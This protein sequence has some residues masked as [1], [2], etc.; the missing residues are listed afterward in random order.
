MAGRT[1]I[2]QPE[3]I[4]STEQYD[5]TLSPGI[6]LQTSSS[7][8]EFDLNALRSQVR[9]IIWADVTGSWYS[10]LTT[11]SF[12]TPSRGIN[13]LNE[14]LADLEQHRLIVRTQKISASV[15]VPALANWVTLSVT[16]STAPS[17]APGTSVAIG[18]TSQ[19]G[20][21]VA[22]ATIN[23]WSGAVVSGSSPI[24][25]KNLCVIRDAG[26]GEK[27]QDSLNGNRD[28]YGLF[29]VAS[30][31]ANGN[32]ID[33]STNQVQISFVVEV[34]GSLL[35]A[36]VSSIQNKLINYSY[37][38]RYALDN[39][40]ED[41]FLGNH[42]FI[43]IPF[44]SLNTGSN[45]TLNDITLQRAINNQGSLPVWL[46][47]STTVDLNEFDWKFT[48]NDRTIVNF[49]TASILL[50]SNKIDLYSSGTLSFA[51]SGSFTSSYGGQPILFSSGTS[52]WNGFYTYF[53]PSATI[54][55]AFTALS[56]SISSS[57][58]RTIERAGVTDKVN[59]GVNITFPTNLDVQLQ[60]Y[61]GKDFL[62]DV[63]VYLNGVLL[64]PALT[65]GAGDVYPG[66]NP[67]TGDLKFEQ[68]LRSGSIITLEIF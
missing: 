14:D 54:L 60:S 18:N 53:G 15:V 38:T 44:A 11:S 7:N 13:S 51:D 66:T 24:S 52:E 29:Q 2:S 4:F 28:V 8:L 12:G 67:A 68:K 47:G 46:S 10:Q 50:N 45:V 64:N 48:D 49:S 20:S 25:P 26:N 41:I 57:V 33:D 16:G 61:A 19:T 6:T 17:I 36:S 22:F 23:T 5:D 63:N 34:S 56:Q 43:D 39:L 42:V 27:V 30:T 58:K 37:P 32:A 21:V 9:K 1:F 55:S 65:V 62:N 59:A 31:S 3:Q 35:P 40:P